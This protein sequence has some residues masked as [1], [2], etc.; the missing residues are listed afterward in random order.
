M[1][2]KKPQASRTQA[3][4]KPTAKKKVSK[5]KA[6]KKS[7]AK[8][9]GT[10]ASRR[11]GGLFDSE[12]TANSDRPK[13]KTAK[14]TAKK[15]IRK[16]ASTGQGD[17]AIAEKM[18]AKQKDIS[19]SEFFAKNRHLLGFDS[20]AR[21]LLTTVREA[22]DNS[23]DA[24]EEASVLPELIIDVRA[25]ESTQHVVTIRDN[26]PGIV[27][28]QLPRIFA[29]L[30][31]G[32]KFHSR[33]QTRGQQGIGISAAGMY[34]TLTT[35]KPMRVTS[36]TSRRKPAVELVLAID[37]AKNQPVVKKESEV[38]V[39]WAH[40]T[41]VQIELEGTYKKGKHSIDSF[42]DQVSLAN[43]HVKI[44]YSN[45]IDEE[46][47]T[48]ERVSKVLPDPPNEILPHPHGVELGILMQMMKE[49]SSRTVS[50]FLCTEFCR[51]TPNVVKKVS[52]ETEGLGKK[53]DTDRH[54]KR[55]SSADVKIL[56][57]GIEAT[58]MMA[59]PTN[60]L[61]PIGE[62]LMAK[63]LRRNFDPELV[64]TVTRQPSVY[65]G[66]PFQVEAGIAWGGELPGDDL[67][68][69]FRFANRVPLQYEQ[70]ACAITQSI[71]G[72]PWKNYEIQQARGA[73]PTG[74]LAVLVHIASVWVP[75][76]SESKKAVASYDEILKEMRLAIME[77]GRKLAIHLRKKRRL[78]DAE[79]KK[80]YIKTYIPQIG[81]ALQDILTLSD[82]QRTKA[83]G[84]LSEVLERSRKM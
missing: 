80:D 53:I 7:T 36:R 9:T 41:E 73:L 12:P 17:M 25:T 11:Q 51:V 75:F 28:E 23:L 84:N 22:V 64:I 39:E 30:L 65:R 29:R 59:P 21:A 61:S 16:S 19:V 20:P 52:D 55:L 35:G 6:S 71:V 37:M 62:E 2:R 44:V 42:L 33:K 76:T 47:I 5:K 60:C 15:S 1:P 74:P 49:T 66:N 48:W 27:R 40:G 77:A 38:E 72:T 82:T 31:Y 14:K 46:P 32:S 79:R 10:A 83:E 45:P 34:G 57:K 68:S 4:S 8:K 58:R 70:G 78:A 67:A 43:P 3:A 56:H 50:G 63:T 26:G 69:I 13:K 54:P 18:A 81:I 24:C